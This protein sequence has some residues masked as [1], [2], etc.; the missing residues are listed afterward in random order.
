MRDEVGLELGRWETVLECYGMLNAH[1]TSIV[2]RVEAVDGHFCHM[3]TMIWVPNV[4]EIKSGRELVYVD[5]KYCI[6][7]C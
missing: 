4:G 2:E 3:E 7:L 5:P 1:M 6:P